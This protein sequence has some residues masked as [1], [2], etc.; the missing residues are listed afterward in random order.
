LGRQVDP[1]FDA[2][3]RK[4]ENLYRNLLSSTCLLGLSGDFSTEPKTAKSFKEAAGFLK[5]KYNL[6]KMRKMKMKAVVLAAGK[7]VR[8]M[9][10]TEDKPKVLV[11]ISGKPFLYYALKNLEEA[12]YD[13][14][15]IVAGY[16]KEKVKEFVKSYIS[17]EKYSGKCNIKILVQKEQKGTGDALRT[18]KKFAGADNFLVY[19][20]DNFYCV[21]DLLEI[22]R[23]SEEEKINY[24]GAV[25]VKC[26]EKYGILQVDGWSLKEI[27][28]KPKEYVGN[29]A[30]AGLYYFT[31]DIFE[32]LEKVKL[33]IRGEIELTDAVTALAK[34]GK[35]KVMRLE[36]GFKDLGCKEDIPLMEKF[37]RG[38]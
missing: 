7:G 5:D 8:M 27:I 15:G 36:G 20:G 2:T 9:P 28:E 35:V 18:A 24:I 11:E 3:D 38:C 19:N 4:S 17:D 29:L 6:K 37:L 14:I 10:L 13:Q 21:K 22:R 25:E 32:E 12:G 34:K 26:P 23:K 30:N 31:P 1:I 33:S 16:K